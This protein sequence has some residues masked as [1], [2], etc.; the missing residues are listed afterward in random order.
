MKKKII[1]TVLML[2][3]LLVAIVPSVYESTKIVNYNMT[4]DLSAKV[5]GSKNMSVDRDD[6]KTTDD[7]VFLSQLIIIG[8]VLDDGKLSSYNVIGNDAIAQEIESRGI[9]TTAA[10]TLSQVRIDRVI[11]GEKPKSDTITL[12]QL[13]KPGVADIQTKVKKSEKLLL[14]LRK[15]GEEDQPQYDCM[16]WENSVFYIEKGNKLLSMSDQM[17]CAKYDGLPLDKLIDDLKTSFS[18][19]PK[20]GSLIGYD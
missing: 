3:L 7:L 15:T 6:P 17:A 13:G 1:I 18:N 4:P 16:D 11:A 10:C 5:V 12:F 9:S 19:K 20:A 8:T 14:I 2:V